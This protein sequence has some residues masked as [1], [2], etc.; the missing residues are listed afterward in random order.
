MLNESVFLAEVTPYSETP[1]T[2]IFDLKGISVAMI[3]IR[4][5]CKW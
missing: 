1:I 3:P 2:A 4:E 5:N